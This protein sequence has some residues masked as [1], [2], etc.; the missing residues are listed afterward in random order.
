MTKRIV[1]WNSPDGRTVMASADPPGPGWT[2]HSQQTPPDIPPLTYPTF[3]RFDL[4]GTKRE[5]V[6]D[7]ADALGLKVTHQHGGTGFAFILSGG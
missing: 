4:T 3:I 6:L 7:A 1:Q 5:R 2:R